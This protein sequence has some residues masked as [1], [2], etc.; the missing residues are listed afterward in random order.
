MLHPRFVKKTGL[1]TEISGIPNFPAGINTEVNIFLVAKPE[2]IHLRRKGENVFIR[3][4]FFFLI[5]LFLIKEDDKVG[6]WSMECA[7]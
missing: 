4:V 5:M 6:S 2:G 7:F 3:F 1:D